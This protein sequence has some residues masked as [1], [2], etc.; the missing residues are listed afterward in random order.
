MEDNQLDFTSLPI[1]DYNLVHNFKKDEFLSQLRKALFHVG[2]L[3]IKNH[4][5]P[6]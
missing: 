4:P 2:F 1:L 6:K 5:I 3:Y